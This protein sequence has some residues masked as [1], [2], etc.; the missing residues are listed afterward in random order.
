MVSGLLARKG[1][2]LFESAPAASPSAEP[3]AGAETSRQRKGQV[4]EQEHDRQGK[5]T[6]THGQHGGKTLALPSKGSAATS[7][8]GKG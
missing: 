4:E 2:A 8:Q 1:K 6:Q 5:R 3:G 7:R